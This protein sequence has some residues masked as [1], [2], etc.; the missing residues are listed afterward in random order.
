MLRTIEQFYPDPLTGKMKPGFF[1]GVKA[2]TGVQALLQKI[3][4]LILLAPGTNFYNPELGNIFATS[5]GGNQ[6][7]D[8]TELKIKFQQGL[9]EIENKIKEEQGIEVNL[10]DEEKL[11]KLEMARFW[12]DPSDYTVIEIDVLVTT[13]ANETYILKV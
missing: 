5:I 11:L 7:A 1:V 8:E 6:S 4:R 12:R 10:V 2:A 9:I 3:A 13:V